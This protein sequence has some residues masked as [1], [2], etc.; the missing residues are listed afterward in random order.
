ML[1]QG[2]RRLIHFARQRKNWRIVAGG[3]VLVLL[4]ATSLL[5]FLMSGAPSKRAA[6]GTGRTTNGLTGLANL[7]ATVPERIVYL[8][9]LPELETSGMR[10]QG[11]DT[12]GKGGKL[13][14]PR[15]NR[16]SVDGIPF[17]KALNTPAPNGTVVVSYRLDKKYRQFKCAVALDDSLA[18][19]DVTAP[20]R[21]TVMGDTKVLW[22]SEP[23]RNRKER[24]E[25]V[26]SVK[27]VEHIDLAANYEGAHGGGW[28]AVWLD[29]LLTK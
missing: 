20:L 17:A 18:G 7:P 11:N 24:Q 25:F 21:F 2:P 22:R 15:G 3:G 28:A 4:L 13:G 10:I 27:G 12:F 1:R 29:P 23:L 26:I 14:Y 6:A 9:D 5:L 19:A 8:S 16:I